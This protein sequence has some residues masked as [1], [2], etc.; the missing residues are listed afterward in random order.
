MLQFLSILSHF[1]IL[2]CLC[3]GAQAAASG[4]P[5]HRRAPIH[6]SFRWPGEPARKAYERY[7]NRISQFGIVGP[8]RGAP[9]T[10]N[11]KKFEDLDFSKLGSWNNPQQVFAAFSKVRD[12]RFISDPQYSDVKRRESWLFPDDGC[13]S[14]A[15]LA[16]QNLKRW[17]FPE[18]KKIFVFGDLSVRTPNHPSGGVG[19][20]VHVAPV[21]RLGQAVYVFDPSIAPKRPLAIG[22]W[23]SKINSNPE[24][25][26]FAL[27]DFDAYA[28]SSECEKISGL[29]E[30]TLGLALS[31]QA[32]FLPLERSRI[33]A[34][35]R[36]PVR[37]L[38]DYPPWKSDN[39]IRSALFL[40]E[41]FP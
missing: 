8:S 22:E 11:A 37:E 14:R 2:A 29:S 41:A 31:D 33:E 38:G 27:C 19:W 7:I 4:P 24:S 30:G 28:P 26:T 23:A 25:L 21:V 34:L 17:G 1:G 16:I 36:N 32:Y 15:T 20:W 10:A 39:L 35:G 5:D 18:A 13:F 40:R 3:S 9:V 6:L 12:E